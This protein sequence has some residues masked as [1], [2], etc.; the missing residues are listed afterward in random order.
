MTRAV[1]SLRNRLGLPYIDGTW[2]CFDFE[3][4]NENYGDARRT[5]NRVVMVSWCEGQGDYIG[6]VKSFYGNWKDCPE[7]LATLKRND[8]ALAQHCKFE[9][10][11]LLRG[12]VDAPAMFWADTM[13]F[14]WVLLGN[15]PKRLRLE[16]GS[17]AKRYGFQGKERLVAA[18]IKGGVCPSLIPKRLLIARCERDV[19]TTAQVARKQV[20]LLR[21][22]GQL[23]VAAL[24]CLMAPVLADIERPGLMLDKDRVIAAHAEYSYKLWELRQNLLALIGQVGRG[25]TEMVPLVYGVWP[26]PHGK[27][28]GELKRSQAK[29]AEMKSRI[30]PLFFDEPRDWRGKPR[31]LAVTKSWPQGRPKLDKRTLVGL[32]AQVKNDRQRQWIELNAK[33]GQVTAALSKNLDFYLGVVLERQGWY[34]INLAQGITATHRL[35]GLGVPV[36]FDMYDGDELS[37]QPQNTPREF[38]KLHMARTEGWDSTPTDSAQLEFRM[39]AFLG[40][41]PVAM[42]DIR[43][44]DFDAHL[45]TLTVMLFGKLLP[46]EYAKL[47]ERYRAGDK[48]VKWQRNDNVLCKAHTYKPLFGGES[49]TPVQESYYR[50]FREHYSGVTKATLNW[51]RDVIRDGELWSYGMCFRFT[52]GYKN[53]KAFDLDRKKPLKP[54]VANYPIQRL[55]TGE[56]MPIAGVCLYHRIK[57]K[58]LRALLNNLVHDSADGECHPDDRAAYVQEAQQAFT[59]DVV[60]WFKDCYG[61]AFN[62]PLGCETT[63]GRN[64]GEGLKFAFDMK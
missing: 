59:T 29:L 25:P 30:Q 11:W 48:Q 1:L 57:E 5:G 26:T 47:L 33:L 43:N 31:R 22:R 58:G 16:L 61:I 20:A 13:L 27:T 56:A 49:G 3:T 10:H 64:L 53:D 34:H 51:L 15:N 54:A 14:E 35:S 38:K 39:A 52:V 7:F 63:A 8:Y 17:M 45:Q 23:A 42:A 2:V 18:L 41:D 55:A 36:A 9:S 19:L 4:T 12:G 62:V 40:Q 6:P 32:A 44:P 21:Q 46:E 50:W 24:R 60:D 37:A 28:A